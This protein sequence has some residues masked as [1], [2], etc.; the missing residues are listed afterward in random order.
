MYLE[1]TYRK[2]YQKIGSRC[3][4]WK[5]NLCILCA[6]LVLNKNSMLGPKTVEIPYI[7]VSARQ[8]MG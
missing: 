5:A 8:Y 7:S 6:I 3:F 4:Y 1:R 2:N